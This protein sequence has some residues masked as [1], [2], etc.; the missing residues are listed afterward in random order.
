MNKNYIDFSYSS[1]TNQS[2]RCNLNK[3]YDNIA[4]LAAFICGVLALTAALSS[5]AATAVFGILGFAIGA[6]D[7]YIP[8]HWIDAAKTDVTWKGVNPNHP[9]DSKTLS[10][11][12]YVMNYQGRGPETLIDG[13][14]AQPPASRPTMKRLQEHFMGRS[15][16]GTTV[17][18]W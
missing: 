4:S 7:V 9:T 10:G 6:R 5:L 17:L 16:A 11:A 14:F 8:E 15:S 2:D 1:M 13:A 12:K 18:K 3:K